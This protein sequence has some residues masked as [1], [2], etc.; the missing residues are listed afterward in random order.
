MTPMRELRRCR[1]LKTFHVS[2][3][4]VLHILVKGE[5]WYKRG[6]TLDESRNALQQSGFIAREIS[7]G[8]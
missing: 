2:V 4:F 5:G 3:L 1:H 7:G 6:L 8:M